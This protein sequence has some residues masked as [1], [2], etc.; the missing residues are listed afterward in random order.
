VV[1]IHSPR[2]KQGSAAKSRYHFLQMAKKRLGE[3]LLEKKIITQ[4]QLETALAYHRRSGHRV[5]TSLVLTGAITEATLSHALSEALGL[6]AIDLK[7]TVPEWGALRLLDARF[8]E[9]HDLIPIALDD[10]RGRKVLKVAMADPLNVPAV[11][12]IEFTTGVK[13]VPAIAP[14]STVRAAV[15]AHYRRRS[16]EPSL[17]EEEEASGVM[18]LV[19]PGGTEERIPTDTDALKVLAGVPED[20]PVING[21]E[22]PEDSEVTARSALADLIQKRAEQRKRR[23]KGTKSVADDLSYLTGLSAPDEA[24][25][26]QR[27]EH[28]FWTLLRI[29]AK[30][31]LLTKEEFLSELDED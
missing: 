26:I 9:T 8:C 24:E 15:Q 31:G 1:Q 18:T 10:H 16:Q 6:P 2:K 4:Q 28:R 7:K 19:R 5:G 13:V 22:I 27:L 29:L 23:R 20:A 3:I 30:K 11:E 17:S 14:L 21:L 25:E 12:E